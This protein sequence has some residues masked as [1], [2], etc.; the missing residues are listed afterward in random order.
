MLGSLLRAV[1]LIV[2]LVAVAAFLLGYWAFDTQRAASRAD[3]AV[4]T[5]GVNA[6]RARE[7]GAD[8]GER[9]AT[10]ASE[11]GEKTA[12]AAADARRAL[13]DGTL[14]AKIKAKMALDDTVK[15]LAV[16]VDTVNGA[17][18]LTGTVDSAAQK[19]R[20]LQLARETEG[21]ASVVDRI[22]VR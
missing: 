10:A 15:A 3:E 11:V 18:T 9:T 8:I 4:G 13:G 1:V 5:A 19:E 20:M 16:D 12:A 2:V 22:R 21:V 6:E 14:T 7:V 17:V